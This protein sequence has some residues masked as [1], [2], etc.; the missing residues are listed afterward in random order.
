MCDLMNRPAARVFLNL[1][2][3]TIDRFLG[4]AAK[5]VAFRA[6]ARRRA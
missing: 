4:G 5:P 1:I 2:A 6:P 3:V